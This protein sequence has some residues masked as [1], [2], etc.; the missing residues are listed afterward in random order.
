[1]GAGTSGCALAGRLVDAGLRVLLLE[2]GEDHPAGFPAELRDP[3]RMAAAVPGSSGRLAPRGRADRRAPGAGAARPGGG[4]LQRAQRRRLPAGHPG[5]L[6]RLGRPRQRPLV[7]RTRAAGPP[8]AGERPRLRG[9]PGARSRRTG[10]GAALPGR[11]PGRR[12]VRRRGGGAG[13]PGGAG[14]ERRGSARR[15]AG[16]VQ[17]SR[18]RPGQHRHGVPDAAAEPAGAHRA[19][20]RARPSGA[21]R[22]GARGRRRDLRGG[23]PRRDRGAQRGRGRFRAAPAPLGHRTGRRAAGGRHRRRRRRAGGRDRRERPSPGLPRLASRAPAARRP[24]PAE[25]G[26]PHGR[27]RAP[28]LAHALLPRDVT[29]CR[30]RPRH[31]DRT[32]AGR[33]PG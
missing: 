17:H 28:A 4:R 9:D 3:A 14:Q 32:P 16:A 2:A 33:E 25:R 20:G 7:L 11:S 29:G 1:M 24:A 19:R 31:R 27:G 12:R 23:G 13:L 6:R 21:G 10:A 8:P 30:R 15:R 5:R 26:A 18:R 22:A